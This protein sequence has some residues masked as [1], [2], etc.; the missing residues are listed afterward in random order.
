MSFSLANLRSACTFCVALRQVDYEI[1]TMR[2]VY[3]NR[4]ASQGRTFA[5]ACPAAGSL[6]LD[7]VIELLA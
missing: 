4:A 2:T 7:G 3:A 6:E 1:D 5:P